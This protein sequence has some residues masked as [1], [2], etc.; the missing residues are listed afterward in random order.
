M[1]TVVLTAQREYLQDLVCSESLVSRQVTINVE[2]FD[3]LTESTYF[4]IA[5]MIEKLECLV[6]NKCARS[7]LK[8]GHAQWLAHVLIDVILVKAT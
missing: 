4:S 3:I 1:S 8:K 7:R 2:A 6:G 5:Q